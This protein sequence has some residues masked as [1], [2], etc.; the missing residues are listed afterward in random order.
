[1]NAGQKSLTH[2]TS[3][4]SLPCPMSSIRSFTATRSTCT[5]S[6]TGAALKH[7]WNYLPIKSDPVL[8]RG[9]SRYF[10]PGTMSC[11]TMY[12]CT[13]SSPAVGLPRM[14]NSADYGAAFLSPSGSSGI[15]S[16]EN[17]WHVFHHSMKAA[18]WYFPLP[19]KACVIL[20]PGKDFWT[21]FIKKN[22]ALTL[23]R[24]LTASETPL[25]TW[26]V[27]PIRSPSPT[28][29]S[30]TSWKRMSSFLPERKN[31]RSETQDH[32]F[33]HGVHPALPDAC[34]AFRLPEDPLLWFPE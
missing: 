11:P 5:V 3:M 9:S 26:D 6:C 17:I 27:T 32:S 31:G 4:W 28:A 7:F 20:I 19:A 24:P 21:A 33:T 22:G 13:A 10:T 23:K 12:T 8:H 15:N 14:E 34:A 18:P 25:S 29:E 2:L 16:G 30:L 1:M